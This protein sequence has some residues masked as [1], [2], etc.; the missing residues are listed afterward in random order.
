MDTSF[1]TCGLIPPERAPAVLAGDGVVLHRHPDD[2]GQL[3]IRNSEFCP[4]GGLGIFFAAPKGGLRAGHLLAVYT[5]ELTDSLEISYRDALN[6]WSTSDYVF[7]DAAYRFV[8]NGDLSC[9]AARA[10]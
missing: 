1:T 4:N 6:Q 7:S 3:W 10:N 5:G 2:H 8:V 9:A